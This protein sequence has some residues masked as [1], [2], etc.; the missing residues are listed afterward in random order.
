[1]QFDSQQIHDFNVALNE[2][3]LGQ[4]LVLPEDSLALITVVALALP[5]DDGPP[6]QDPHV[7]LILHPIGRVA[8]SLRDDLGGDGAA[9]V[10][11]FELAQLGT[12]AGSFGHLPLYGWRFLKLP[13]EE[14]FARWR[15]RLSLDWRAEHGDGRLHTLDLFQH[16]DD[17]SRRLDIRIW[18]DVLRIS[19]PDR[20]EVAFDDFTAAG[21]RWWDGLY[22]NDPRTTGWGIKPV[23]RWG[24]QG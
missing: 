15:E 22:A 14:G 21:V 8:A 18:F 10:A 12:V 4:I 5:P 9:T 13:E 1:M 17:G 23:P 24:A 16:T 7:Q 20:R 19:G 11:S 3:L 6:P 2:A